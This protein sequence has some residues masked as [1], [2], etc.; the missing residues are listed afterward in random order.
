MFL[1]SLLEANE[2]LRYIEA[3][4]Q[5][6]RFH[7]IE[8]SECSHPGQDD[9]DPVCAS[10]VPVIDDDGVFGHSLQLVPSCCYVGV[11][12]NLFD[13]CVAHGRRYVFGQREHDTI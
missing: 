6:K 8:P 7:K 13:L 2:I 4:V 12:R 3:A 1:Q 11:H 9:V 5:V 10:I